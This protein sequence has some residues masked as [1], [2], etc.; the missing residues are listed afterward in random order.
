MGFLKN[1][2]SGF[3]EAT[4]AGADFNPALETIMNEIE[5]LHAQ[6]HLDKVVY[7]AE[8]AYEK[9]HAEYAAKG[10][11][12]NAADSQRDVAALKHF[13]EALKKSA[14]TFDSPVKETVEHVLDMYDK[15]SHILKNAFKK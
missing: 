13:M 10:L 12:T 5:E 4:K 8:Q 3:R 11:H 6:G 1:L 14:D 7:D 9:E 15:M 2:I